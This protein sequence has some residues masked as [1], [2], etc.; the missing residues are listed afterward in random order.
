MNTTNDLDT[1]TTD[2]ERKGFAT[3]AAQFALEGY[4]LIKG[5]PAMD[6]QAVYYAMR[7]EAVQQLATLDAAAHYV[8]ALV[9]A[10]DGAG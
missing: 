2:R 8:A 7:L 4:V 3:L 1:P 5:D 9:G 10:G 6:G